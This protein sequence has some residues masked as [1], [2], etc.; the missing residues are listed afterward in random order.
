M[1]FPNH[2]L[3]EC[4]DSEIYRRVEV[5]EGVHKGVDDRINT[6][7]G[8]VY[9]LED[10][11]PIALGRL[12]IGDI[13]TKRN[14]PNQVKRFLSDEYTI[15]ANMF[16]CGFVPADFVRRYDGPHSTLREDWVIRAYFLYRDSLLAD[17]FGLSELSDMDLIRGA[18]YLNG[19][20]DWIDKSVYLE[21]CE[22]YTAAWNE[23]SE[24]IKRDVVSRMVQMKSVCWSPRSVGHSRRIFDMYAY[25]KGYD[26]A[27]IDEEV[28][29]WCIDRYFET[30]Y[31]FYED[32]YVSRT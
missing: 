1:P 13:S 21:R 6:F 8:E 11:V 19:A 5:W 3:P 32:L 26:L 23:I 10:V 2:R 30:T 29:Q 16:E 28:L 31:Q 24:E 12:R 14:L 17:G 22:N 7:T 18:L 27:E 25:A 20:H 9:H 4:I 15:H